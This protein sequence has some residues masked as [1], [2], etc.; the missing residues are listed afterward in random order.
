MFACPSHAGVLLR[1]RATAA[2]TGSNLAALLFVERFDKFGS[3]SAV[4][5][6]SHTFHDV[7][8]LSQMYSCS[9]CACLPDPPYLV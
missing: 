7:L 2:T 1:V 6:P 5:G 9:C 3:L 8:S 4:K